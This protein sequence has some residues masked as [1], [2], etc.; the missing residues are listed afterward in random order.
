MKA[1]GRVRQKSQIELVAKQFSVRKCACLC[2]CLWEFDETHMR[3]QFTERLF[4][5]EENF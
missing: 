4:N 1:D 3:K 2:A 5:E